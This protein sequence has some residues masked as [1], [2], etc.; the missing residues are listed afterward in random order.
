MP[1]FACV[2][3][4]DRR[5]WLLLQERDEHAPI[6]PECWGMSGGHV[7]DG[8]DAEAAAHRELREETGL[9][10]PPGALRHH[11][12]YAVFHEHYGTTDPVDVFVAG[13]DLTD[14][15]VECHE[16]RQ[17]VFVDPATI[18][19]L[20]LTRSAQ[21]ALP[22][23]LASRAHAVARWYAEGVVR[24]AQ[25]TLVDPAGRL[26][27][28]ERDEHAQVAADQWSFPGGGL[29][30]GESYVDAAR[31]ELAEET[32]V[33]L[34]QGS[35]CLLGRWTLPSTLEPL[36]NEFEVYLAATELT[37]ADIECHEGRQMVFVTP[38]STATLP[39]AHTTSV[40]LPDLLQSDLYRKL[41]P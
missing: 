30:P 15:D 23:V 34:P 10:L 35:L 5:G 32:G 19:D 20:P 26:L 9:D 16:G 7:E 8:E 18:G 1:S 13:V 11:A 25:V 36:M 38:A 29:E 27:M 31:R 40:V 3:L 41:V 14:A 24:F 39:L 4:V 2:V 33:D 21:L 22:D 37:D 6:D 28:Q 17:F 12:T